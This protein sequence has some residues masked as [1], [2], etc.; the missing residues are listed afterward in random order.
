MA[1]PIGLDD[2]DLLLL[3]LVLQMLV[4]QLD[5][6]VS[7]LESMLVS[8]IREQRRLCRSLPVDKVRVSWS[9]FCDRISEQHFRRMFRMEIPCFNALCA[10]IIAQIGEDI[11]RSESSIEKSSAQIVPPVSGEVKVALSIRMLAGGSYLDLVP[12]F[13][14]S[15]SAL[16][17]IF[18][19]FLDW[20]LVTLHFPLV[21]WI[22]NSQWHVLSHLA[23]QFS[24]K[25]GGTF[26]GPFGAIDGLAVR[27]KCPTL[28]EV[29]D[30]GNYYC[31][32]GF[33]AVN[34]QAICDKL[35]RFIW[36]FPSNKGSTHD[37]SAFANSQLSDMLKEL[38]TLEALERLGLFLVGDSAYSLTPFM[39]VPYEVDDVKGSC[40]TGKDSF[41]YHL[42]S[43]RIY[44]E[45]AFGELVMRWGIFWRTLRF[46]L[47]KS[48]S[49]INVCML[50]HNFIVDFREGDDTEDREFFRQF[51][52]VMD[53]MQR[54]LTRQT[55]EHPTPVVADNNEARPTGRRSLE[56]TAL[57]QAGAAIR[58]RLTVELMINGLERPTDHDMRY[59]KHGNVYLV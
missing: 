57:R 30:P 16:Y 32:K 17:K 44:I 31:R 37:S 19:N 6:H 4:A 22:R 7:K 35:K 15:T 53:D 43:C 48:M 26:A 49:I 45:C 56:D 18:S 36:C 40:F 51:D 20:I 11:F 58:E 55:G 28:R 10:K 1:L 24:E 41:N 59:N 34:V 29:P 27:I 8:H 9:S 42:S 13:S 52:I 50:L 23:N 39:L 5:S 14:I 12:L 2:G 21:G 38:A 47:K 46:G 25:T 54:H 33:Y 3:V